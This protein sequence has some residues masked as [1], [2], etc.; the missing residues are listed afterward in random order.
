MENKRP[1]L[2]HISPDVIA[3][4]QQERQKEAEIRQRDEPDPDFKAVGIYEEKYGFT[5]PLRVE[6]GENVDGVRKLV[7]AATKALGPVIMRH[8]LTDPRG[9]DID[10]RVTLTPRQ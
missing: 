1:S 10:L 7:S 8:L 6:E 9:C 5:I 4:I 3:K 2:T